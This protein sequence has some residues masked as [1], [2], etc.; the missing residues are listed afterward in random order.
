MSKPARQLG[1]PGDD[2]P[3]TV[4]PGTST[5]YG[6]K[7]LFCR[8]PHEPGKYTWGTCW[9]CTRPL[10]CST[11]TTANSLE[12]LCEYCAAWGTEAAFH[13]HGPLVND[14]PQLRKRHGIVAPQFKD[15]PEEWR[16][17]YDH[18]DGA[19]PRTLKEIL[20]ILGIHA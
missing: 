8:D 12:V 6:R 10:G 7:L 2:K 18:P 15:Y 16:L 20:S 14:P 9:K 13:H 11:C 5:A 3:F 19:D 1:Q 17:Q 4:C